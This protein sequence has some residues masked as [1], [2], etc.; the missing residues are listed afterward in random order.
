MKLKHTHRKIIS[1]NTKAAL[2]RWWIVGMCYF[3]IGFGTQTGGYYSPIDLIFFLGVGIGL[4][5]IVV[6]NPIAYSVFDIVRGGEIINRRRRNRKGYQRALDNL[7]EIGLSMLV[8]ILVYL[9]YQNINQL[10]V[11]LFGLESGTVSVA[12][13]PFGFATLYTLF[14]SLVTGLIYKIKAVRNAQQTPQQC[15]KK[16]EGDAIDL[17]P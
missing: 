6:Y 16:E 4:V 8:V 10:I 1:D 3:M 17:H 7:A 12:G 15:G 2:L 5:T 14:Y 11:V 13:E 9:C